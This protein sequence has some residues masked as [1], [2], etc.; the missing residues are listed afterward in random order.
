[1]FDLINSFK[2]YSSINAGE[3]SFLSRVYS[4]NLVHPASF[5][6]FDSEFLFVQGF[7]A[8]YVTS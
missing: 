3:K 2:K 4:L 7:V 1:M 8:V 5:I 6:G